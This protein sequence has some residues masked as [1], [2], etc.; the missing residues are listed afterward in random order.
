MNECIVKSCN[1]EGIAIAPRKRNL[2]K[3]NFVKVNEVETTNLLQ[4]PAKNNALDLWYC[5]LGQLSVK[6][7]YILQN[8]VS[9]MNL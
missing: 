5:R 8:V 3:I 1:G 6:D 2:Y 9:G 4:S 7:L